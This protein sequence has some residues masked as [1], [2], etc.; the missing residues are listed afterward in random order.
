ML[1][2]VKRGLSGKTRRGSPPLPRQRKALRLVQL[3]FIVLAVGLAA[4]AIATLG[5]HIHPLTAAATLGEPRRPGI[6]E[7]LALGSAAVGLGALAL[8]MGVRVVRGPEP[9]SLD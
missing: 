7:V 3:T 8:A 2:V 1:C 9:Q 6:G 4:L 5:R